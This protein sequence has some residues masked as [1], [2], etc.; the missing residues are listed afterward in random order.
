MTV[1]E[2]LIS[3]IP[4]TG[5]KM[6]PVFQGG[7]IM[8]LIDEV[9]EHP[10]LEY[11]SPNHEQALSMMVD[12]YA[13]IKG[14]GVGMATSGPGAQNMVTGIACAYYDSIPC[15]FITGQVGMFHM[16]GTR[17]VRQ[18]GFQETDVVSIVKSIT[19]YAVLLDK[20]ENARYIFEKAVHMA[21][22]GRPGP[23]LIDIP[24]NIQRAIVNPAELKGY[25]PEEELLKAKQDLD[26]SISDIFDDLKKSERPVILLGGGV[27]IAGQ[28]DTIRKLVLKFQVP[29][30]VTWCAL[31]IFE[32]DN[33]L[34]GGTVGRAGN[35]SANRIIRGA[36]FVLAFG[37]RFAWKAI[38]DENNFTNKAKLVA[39]DIDS[40]ELEDGFVSAQVK[41]QF[42]LKEFLPRMLR[43]AEKVT[44][45]PKKDWLAVVAQIKNDYFRTDTLPKGSSYLNPYDFTEALSEALPPN[46]ILV[47]DT[48]TN[49]CW[50][51]HAYRAKIGQRFIASWGN[52]P[53][54]YAL[55]ASVGAHLANKDAMT[56][57]ING[58]GGMQ[59]NIQELQTIALHQFPIKV[60]VLN[61]D[62]YANVKFPSIDQFEGRF[63]ALGR[64][65]GYG[66][67]DFVKIAGAYGIPAFALKKG[68][69]LMK[70]IKEALLMTGPVVVDV[71]LDPEQRAFED[72]ELV[73]P[74]PK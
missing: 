31:D 36:D 70:K 48:G 42:D 52:S 35:K 21:K 40:G 68:D 29:V 44:V 61:N 47:G 16:K 12:G 26:K 55:P 6:V 62:C 66:A 58:D 37:T 72:D 49:L 5:V 41:L 34:Y 20:A 14:F 39:V 30:V 25:T 13:H 22:S 15:M 17:A 2:Y 24:Y 18:R 67:P 7:A 1:A 64:G 8:K 63:H 51:T 4:G 45:P 65:M 57:V 23:V 73:L 50:F 19:K 32:A 9:G 46:T 56:V 69:D 27:D 33:P 71:K 43:A 54:G 38:I 10:A 74:L 3:L 59:M 28:A 11:V 53:M 60:F